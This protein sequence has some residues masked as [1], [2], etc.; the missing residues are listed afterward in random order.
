MNKKIR[1]S[2]NYKFEL[3][4]MAQR[5]AS[6]RPELTQDGWVIVNRDLPVYQM[7]EDNGMI[8]FRSSKLN[9]RQMEAVT[10]SPF[11]GKL[12]QLGLDFLRDKGFDFPENTP[13]EPTPPNFEKDETEE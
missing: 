5:L 4:L 6:K 8:V 11:D 2:S 13:V 12:T 1:L 10:R 9:N 3:E 7:L